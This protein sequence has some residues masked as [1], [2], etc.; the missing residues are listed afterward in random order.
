MRKKFAIVG[1]MHSGKTTL[2]KYLIERDFTR[3]AFA[4]PVK[5][6][7]A[8]MLTTFVRFVDPFS[9]TTY[10]IDHM[11]IMK[12]H[13]AIRKL[14]QLVGT[15]LGREWYGPESLWI[16]LFQEAV[17]NYEAEY[18]DV[19]LINDDC[20]FVNE[21][22]RLSEMGFTLV[23]LVRDETERILSVQ[24]AVQRDNPDLTIEQV[25]AKVDEMLAHPSE[26]NVDLIVPD[27]IIP[28]VTVRQLEQIATEMEMLKLDEF[29]QL[30]ETR[31]Q[32]IGELFPSRTVDDRTRV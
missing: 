31:N 1:K 16:D 10:T 17:A 4:D 7:S 30:N 32:Q 26:T 12:G 23:K 14:L 22:E 25:C 19:Y 20:R 6:V 15:E 9:E 18:H 3:I 21:A 5:A 13:P 28:S 27:I 2:A 11:N 8:E 29:L 24:H